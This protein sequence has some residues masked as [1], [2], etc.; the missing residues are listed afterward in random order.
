M[1]QIG[2]ELALLA[3]RRSG[4]RRYCRRSKGSIK[5]EGEEV[6][7]GIT[8]AADKHRKEVIADI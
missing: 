3:K 5:W 6:M 4:I 2:G 1:H 7:I 8:T